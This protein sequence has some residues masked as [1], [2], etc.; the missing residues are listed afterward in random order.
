MASKGQRFKAYS[1]ELKK[2]ILDKYFSN[3]GS[4]RSL[5]KQFGISFRTINNWIY[6]HNHGKDITVDHRPLSSG[7][8]KEENIDYKERYEILKNYQAFLKAQREKK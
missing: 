4:A 5:A 3:Q 1:P 6:K 2:E 8:R 7:P